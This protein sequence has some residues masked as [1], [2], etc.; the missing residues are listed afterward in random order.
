MKVEV[1]QKVFT[2][3]LQ[4]IEANPNALPL[5]QIRFYFLSLCFTLIL[6]FEWIVSVS[7]VINPSIS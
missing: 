1:A 4:P 7:V 2:I 3:S 5:L 6:V